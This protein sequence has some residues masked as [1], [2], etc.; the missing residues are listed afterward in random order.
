MSRMGVTVLF[1]SGMPSGFLSP[2]DSRFSLKAI[3][4]V[5]QFDILIYYL[6]PKVFLHPIVVFPRIAPSMR[7]AI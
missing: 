4:F 2:N 1:V 3:V 7:T 5:W 6:V